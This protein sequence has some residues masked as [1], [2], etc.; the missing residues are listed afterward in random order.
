VIPFR[1]SP[2]GHREAASALRVI[3]SGSEREVEA[4]EAEAARFLGLRGAVAF[5]TGSAAAALALRALGA[6]PGAE[7]LLP[8]Y[9]RPSLL[10]AVRQSGASPVA[11][12]ILWY[13]MN[14]SIAQARRRM[15]HRAAAVLA[16]HTFGASVEIEPLLRLGL[17]L[18]EDVTQALGAQDYNRRKLG[19]FGSAAVAS[20]DD[21]VLSCG[22][23]GGMVVS[24]DRRVL[25][26]ARAAR[27][28]DGAE[29]AMTPLQ[30]AVGR[31]QLARLPVLLSAR[32]RAADRLRAALSGVPLE[33]PLQIYG[34]VY[35][36]FV[37]R[38]R[39]P[40]TSAL[41]A[42]LLRDRVEARRPLERPLHWDLSGNAAFPVAERVWR[43]SL[44]LPFDGLLTEKD[45]LL[46]A[47]ALKK[48]F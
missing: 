22:G 46:T 27:D 8:A 44:A 10:H 2:F 17:P 15:T 35:S 39:A 26:A 16:V 23:G 13:D 9:A 36:H 25:D 37:V 33:T 43:R 34:R 14:L 4:F 42:G 5:H 24:N 38:L 30:A 1:R 45:I 47:A 28:G 48:R 12:D 40:V 18:L 31:A 6:G 7:V 21:G 11:A 32:R 20:F 3:R 29:L 41:L 19:T